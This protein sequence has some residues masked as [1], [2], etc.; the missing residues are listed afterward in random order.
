[1]HYQLQPN[2]LWESSLLP[3][4][5]LPVLRTKN[6]ED[7]TDSERRRWMASDCDTLEGQLPQAVWTGDGLLPDSLLPGTQHKIAG[8]SPIYPPMNQWPSTSMLFLSL[9]SQLAVATTHIFPELIQPIAAPGIFPEL[10]LPM[11]AGY[12]EQMRSRL[13][14]IKMK[15][16]Q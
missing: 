15:S 13:A 5:T 8:G 2:S 6:I 1:M 3:R 11:W 14:Q 9:M 10:A 12:W 16:A 4:A 7:M